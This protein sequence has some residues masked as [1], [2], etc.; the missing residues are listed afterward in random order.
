MCKLIYIY[1]YITINITIIIWWVIYNNFYI[2]MKFFSLNILGYRFC[3]FFFL[4]LIII[5]L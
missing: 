5:F 2:R 4:V 3:I 1:I